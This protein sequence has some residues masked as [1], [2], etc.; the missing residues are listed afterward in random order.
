[1]VG[2][3]LASVEREPV[4]LTA[5][6]STVH[7]DALMPLRA[8]RLEAPTTEMEVPMFKN[9]HGTK[10]VGIDAVPNLTDVMHLDTRREI[11]DVEEIGQAVSA[12]RPVP[13]VGE[14]VALAVHRP[15]PEPAAVLILDVTSH[16]LL[17][18]EML[19]GRKRSPPPG[20]LSHGP[21]CSA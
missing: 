13:V 19:T 1:V 21:L 7:N 6:R 12:D 5:S 18:G 11:P 20:R 8:E 17:D 16:L 10:V 3:V 4:T 15:R 14:A 9:R 2:L